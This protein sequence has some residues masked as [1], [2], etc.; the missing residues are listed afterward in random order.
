MEVM[1][2]LG[3]CVFD[4]SWNWDG[5]FFSTGSLCITALKMLDLSYLRKSETKTF[6]NL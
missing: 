3:T 6:K 4:I 5:G 1:I 2:A